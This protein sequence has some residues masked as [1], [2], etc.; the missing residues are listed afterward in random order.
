MEIALIWAGY[1][2][3][4]RLRSAKSAA[5]YLVWIVAVL[6]A[7]EWYLPAGSLTLM[8][9]QRKRHRVLNA[10][11]LADSSVERLASPSK[12]LDR[13]AFH[14][15]LRYPQRGHYLTFPAYLGT[16]SAPVA[17]GNYFKKAHPE[18]LDEDFIF[19]PG[20]PYDYLVVFDAN[21][22]LLRSSQETAHIQICD[23]KDY[24]MTCRTVDV[25][26]TESLRT[27]AAAN[28]ANLSV[29]P[30][31]PADNFW[32]LQQKSLRL[33]R[34]KL[35]SM[36]HKRGKP[37]EF[38]FELKN[39]GK[40]ALDIPEGS[41]AKLVHINFAW[42]PLS[43]SAKKTQSPGIVRIGNS[44]AAGGIFGFQKIDRLEAGS[45]VALQGE[46]RPFNPLEPGDY[47]LHVFLFNNYA[48]DSA[49]AEQDLVENFSI[50]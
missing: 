6:A 9:H 34:L 23:G 47:R 19:E 28:P 5:G 3:S 42:E 21:P 37:V 25:D 1:F 44:V 2:F 38:S 7:A 32:S 17:Y 24:F 13:F 10:I 8:V 43:D 36:R 49:S 27:A 48:T 4:R 30:T 11:E 33:A 16:R 46:I 40:A 18:Y 50:N 39:T 41:L 26:L 45:S 31:A 20:K 29:E 15:R 35:D 14:Y 22:A 12:N